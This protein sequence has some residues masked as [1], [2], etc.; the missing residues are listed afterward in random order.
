MWWAFAY[1]CFIQEKK[2]TVAKEVGMV[3]TEPVRYL[4]KNKTIK[5]I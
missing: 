1:V 2:T 5:I 3:N 4:K